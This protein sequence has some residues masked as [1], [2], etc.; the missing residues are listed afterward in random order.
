M[1]IIGLSDVLPQRPQLPARTQIELET[2]AGAL[3][4]PH[5][6]QMRGQHYSGNLVRFVLMQAIFLSALSYH[7]SRACH[8]FQLCEACKECEGNRRCEGIGGSLAGGRAHLCR[9]EVA[10]QGKEDTHSA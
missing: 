6:R 5:M 4:T 9:A 1:L 8:K 3:S 2:L 10:L 7:S